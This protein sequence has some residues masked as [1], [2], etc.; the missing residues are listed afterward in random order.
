MNSK[1]LIFAF[2]DGHTIITYSGHINILAFWKSLLTESQWQTYSKQKYMEIN[3]R[4][5]SYT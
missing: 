2:F 1:R 5:T 4:K 3:N